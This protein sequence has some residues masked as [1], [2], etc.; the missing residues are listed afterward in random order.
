MQQA[1]GDNS[2]FQMLVLH[3][4]LWA[5]ADSQSQSR[6]LCKSK[7]SIFILFLEFKQRVNRNYQEQKVKVEERTDG[8]WPPP[9]MASEEVPMIMSCEKSKKPRPLAQTPVSMVPTLE[10]NWRAIPTSYTME[11]IRCFVNLRNNSI[12]FG[13]L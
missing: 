4:F 2:K 5:V 10:I 11:I 12:Q 13:V 7:K 3:I 9:T 6:V 1:K 8:N